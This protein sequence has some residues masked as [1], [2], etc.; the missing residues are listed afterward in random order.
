MPRRDFDPYASCCFVLEIDGIRAA[1]FS[2]CSGLQMETKVFEYK[3]GGNNKTTLRFPEHTSYGNVTLKRGIIASNELLRWQADVARG[4]FSDRPRDGINFA[5]IFLDE[6]GFELKR[7]NL[8]RA[9]P[10]KWMGPDLKASASEI[11]IESVE[12]AHEGI[13]VR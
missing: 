4:N 11:A 10:V 6:Q 1:G 7:W 13:Q 3:E 5:I 12:I 9:Y 8:I 2:D